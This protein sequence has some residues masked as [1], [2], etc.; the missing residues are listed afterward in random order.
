MAGRSC[1]EWLRRDG[2]PN[3]H[4]PVVDGDHGTAIW[5]TP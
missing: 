2:G 1:P 5:I 3:G 4:Y